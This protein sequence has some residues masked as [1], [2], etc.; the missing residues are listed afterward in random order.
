MN[1]KQKLK[2]KKTVI[3]SWITL[4]HPIIPEIM[5]GAGFDFL[6]IEMEH[7]VISLKDTQVLIQSIQAQGVAPL[8]RLGENDPNLIKRVMDAGAEG[9]II[10]FVNSAADAKKA[11]DAVKY[12]PVG[13]RGVGLA[14]AQKYGF[15]FE[16]YKKWAKD[17]SLV[18]ALI[19]HIRAV[20]NLESILSVPG[21]DGTLI[22]P[23]DLSGSLGYP[24]EFERPE[25]RKAMDRYESICKKMKKPMGFHVVHP[26]AAKVLEK[27]KKGYRF[28]AVGLDTLYLGTKCREVVSGLRAKR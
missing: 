4:A 6:V 19:E 27:K 25:V 12:P 14:R 9:V 22:G 26:D 17:D 16:A 3:G 21:L 13:T 11:V 15:G 10:A 2:N 5:A 7:S 8:V 18:I 1:L 24:G 28:L 23:Y 20:E